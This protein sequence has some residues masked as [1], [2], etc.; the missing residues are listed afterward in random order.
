MVL[1]ALVIVFVVRPVAGLIGLL[2]FDRPWI[3]RGVI[4]FFGVRGIGSF[5]YLAHSLNEAA[6]TSVDHI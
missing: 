5:Y 3:E 1:A 4:A 6:F 2:G